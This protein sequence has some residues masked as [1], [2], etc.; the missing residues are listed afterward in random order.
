VK[1]GLGDGSAAFPAPAGKAALLAPKGR[2]LKSKRQGARRKTGGVHV[3]PR[4][5]KAVLAH[6]RA[7]L[8]GHFARN[9]C[10]RA[11]KVFRGKGSFRPGKRLQ[12]QPAA[13]V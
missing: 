5:E 4:R 12:E 9:G 10:K 2:F 13:V 3:P 1:S 11:F 7:N 8:K 6:S